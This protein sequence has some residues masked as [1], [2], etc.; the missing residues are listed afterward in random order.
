MELLYDHTHPDPIGQVGASRN[1]SS[2]N[3]LNDVDTIILDNGDID[4]QENDRV[5][6]LRRHT[7]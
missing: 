3:L 7:R 2:P 6:G 1:D 4:L 5:V